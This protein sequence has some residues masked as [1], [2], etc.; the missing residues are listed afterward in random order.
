MHHHD[1][2]SNRDPVPPPAAAPARDGPAA[3]RTRQCHHVI[4]HWTTP[5]ERQAIL[6]AIAYA[7]RI[8][9]LAALPLLLDRLTA[10]CE[11]RDGRHADAWFQFLA[12]RWDLACARRLAETRDPGTFDPR[13]WFGWL[14]AVRI[15]ADTLTEQDWERPVIAVRIREAY[16]SPMI[17]DG[18]HRIARA[19]DTH[20]TRLP[21]VVLEPDEEYH[22]R[23]FGG[24]K[25]Q[26]DPPGEGPGP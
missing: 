13:G 11:A 3:N 16:N 26:P 10:P 21:I 20:L 15:D 6:D 17:I 18:W 14:D 8:G 4:A 1:N 9:D 2:D 24:D 23:I 22:V 7:R 5:D 19:R 12:Y 25:G